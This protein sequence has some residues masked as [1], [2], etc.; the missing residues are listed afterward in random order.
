MS[1]TDEEKKTRERKKK[2]AIR[3][4]A[5]DEAKEAAIRRR[6]VNVRLRAELKAERRL[7]DML[8]DILRGRGP[9]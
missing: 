8:K 4:A 3:N 7:G 9:T 1:L 6:I 2:A 5:S